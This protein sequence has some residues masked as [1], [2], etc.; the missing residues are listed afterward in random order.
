[1]TD[2]NRNQADSAQVLA[3]SLTD[4]MGRGILPN[5]LPARFTVIEAA[6]RSDEWRRARAGRLTGSMAHIIVMKGKRPGEESKTRRDYILQLVTERIDGNSQERL[7]HTADIERGIRLEPYAFSAYEAKQGVIVQRSGFLQMNEHLAGCSLDGHMGNYSG[8]LELKCPKMATHIRY[9]EDPILLAVEY[10]LQCTHN[11][12]V[13]GAAYCDL[14]SFNDRLPP[15]KQLVHVRL[16]RYDAH[17]PE[18]EDKA[19]QFL[20]EV[21]A[22]YE[23]IMDGGYS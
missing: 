8:I 17:L 14:I 11:L 12:W 13:T 19:L 15:K 9:Y 1:M 4:P 10:A 2:P 22:R 18:Y 7:F 5:S 21:D 16:A 6:Q 20:K 3:P 23:L